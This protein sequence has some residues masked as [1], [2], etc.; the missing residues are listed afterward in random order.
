MDPDIKDCIT[1]MRWQKH[2]LQRCGASPEL[3]GVLEALAPG[4][5]DCNDEE[6]LSGATVASEDA[7]VHEEAAKASDLLTSVAKSRGGGVVRC[8]R[9]FGVFSIWALWLDPPVCTSAARLLSCLS[10]SL[11]FSGLLCVSLAVSVSAL[12]PSLFLALS[13]SPSLSLVRSVCFCLCF[14]LV[15]AFVCLIL[16]RWLRLCL[17]FWPCF[18]SLF[19][20]CL[21]L[22]RR[23]CLRFRLV[24]SFCFCVLPVSSIPSSITVP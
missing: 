7:E 10:P 17:C 1:Y 9:G 15:F 24:P 13:L 16:C 21:C 6:S 12:S 23:L 4:V 20:R 3:R 2:C 18:V 19:P 5:T 14:C 11:S 8:G 22:R